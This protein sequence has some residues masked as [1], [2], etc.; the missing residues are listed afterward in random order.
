MTAPP[1]LICGVTSSAMPEKNGVSSMLGVDCV[2]VLVMV[3][4]D[5]SV[6]K[7]FIGANLN[8]RFLIVH[9]RDAGAGQNLDVALPFEQFDEG[10]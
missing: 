10:G 2:A 3:V 1:S 9:S 6:T 8:D 7:E 5:T 4:V